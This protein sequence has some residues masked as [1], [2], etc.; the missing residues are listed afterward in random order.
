MLF[1]NFA[2]GNEVVLKQNDGWR[3]SLTFRIRDNLWLP[4]FIN[5]GNH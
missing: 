5:M 4:L 3:N 1:R 2:N